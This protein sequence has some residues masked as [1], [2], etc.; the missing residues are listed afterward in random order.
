MFNSNESPCIGLCTLNEE[1]L[2]LG[3]GRALNEITDW[4]SSSDE[5]KSGICQRAQERVALL[6]SNSPTLSEARKMK[7]EALRQDIR[8]NKFK[9]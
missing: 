5:E 3:C 2:C 6:E 7:I 9:G 4:H 1:N 8:N